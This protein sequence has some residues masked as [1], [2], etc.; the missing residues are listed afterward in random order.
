[1]TVD[2]RFGVALKGTPPRAN[3]RIFR[4]MIPPESLSPVFPI[5]PVAFQLLS[6]CFSVIFRHFPSFSVI[7]RCLSVV[8][9]P[10]VCLFAWNYS[11]M[12]GRVMPAAIPK[13]V[14]SER[15]VSCR[16]YIK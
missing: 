7:F 14:L 3:P 11:G 8:S 6:S 12:S 16:S 2:Y 9:F 15:K 13:E 4:Q 1:M 10:I 5:F